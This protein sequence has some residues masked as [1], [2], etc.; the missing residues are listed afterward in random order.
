MPPK[1]SPPCSC[2]S[3]GGVLNSPADPGQ[4]PG[5]SGGGGANPPEGLEILKLT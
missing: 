5:G 2:G 3:G 4:S 1:Q